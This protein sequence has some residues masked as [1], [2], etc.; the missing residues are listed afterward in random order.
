MSEIVDAGQHLVP[1]SLLRAYR[2]AGVPYGELAEVTE[3][4][5]RLPEMDA[6]GVGYGVI[7]IP[8]PDKY[9]H[10]RE[11]IVELAAACNDEL[12][13]A[14]ESQPGRFT[15]LAML[16]LPF[17]DECVAELERVRA[18]PLVKGVILFATTSR[19]TLDEPRL[20]PVFEAIADAGL[21]ALVHPAQEELP[22]LPVFADWTIQN[23]IPTMMESSVA[24]ARLMLSGTLD[25]VPSLTLIVP[26]LGGVL[27]YLAQRAV[28]Q[29]GTGAARHN[30]LH[31][32]KTR[33]LLDSCSYHP[34]ALT[35]AVSTVTADR[36]V[37]GTDYPYRG[38]IG[39]AIDDVEQ[40]GLAAL[41]QAAILGGTARRH[42]LA[43]D[44]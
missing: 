14:A 10:E 22:R 33:C 19:W 12:L 40:A 43:L 20:Q 44:D 25:R 18:H 13:A 26:H 42:G 21:P 4:E 5:L 39:R 28:D 16:P 35:C 38:P 32:L 29:S 41:E 27:P 15:I 17:V 24:V 8:V 1:P 7:S 31:Y 30:V 34:P 11:D 23:W 6:R 37:M 36:I 9:D 3:L 2:A